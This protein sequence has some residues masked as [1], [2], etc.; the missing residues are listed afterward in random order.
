MTSSAGGLLLSWC[1]GGACSMKHTCQSGIT[2]VSADRPCRQPQLGQLHLHLH[3][4]K[5][6][7]AGPPSPRQL[8]LHFLCA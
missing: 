3:L 8:A 1:S 2:Q 6:M 4:F 7:Q 5:A